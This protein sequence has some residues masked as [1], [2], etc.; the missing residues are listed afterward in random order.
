MC[1]AVPMQVV[2]LNEKGIVAEIDGVQREASL[3]MLDAPVTRGDF[4][5]VHAGFAIAKIGEEEA[6]ETL[7]LMR[8][9]MSLASE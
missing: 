9:V 4:V 8:E 1:L 2:S 3:M 5:L 7:E 6:K